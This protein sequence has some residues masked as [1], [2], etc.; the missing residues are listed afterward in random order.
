M[1]IGVWVEPFPPVINNGIGNWLKE[2]W[3]NQM[4][5]HVF[6]FP[7]TADPSNLKG[8]FLFKDIRQPM[9]LLKSLRSPLRHAWSL[10]ST[11]TSP[12]LWSIWNA[13]LYSLMPMKDPLAVFIRL[14]MAK[15]WQGKLHSYS[16]HTPCSFKCLTSF[17][18]FLL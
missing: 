15:R 18:L 7:N 11:E 12:V 4:W 13:E 5:F 3:D 14:E 10:S 17:W 9:L 6:S 16:L 8:H 1:S 2:M